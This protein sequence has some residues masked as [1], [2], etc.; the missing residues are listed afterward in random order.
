MMAVFWD[1][2]VK[3]PLAVRLPKVTVGPVAVFPPVVIASVEPALMATLVAREGDIDAEVAVRQT[4]TVPVL[5]T[6]IVPKPLSAELAVE[7]AAILSVPLSK[8][9]AL[10]PKNPPTPVEIETFTLLPVG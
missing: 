7:F 8:F 6:V 3:F 1:C 4:F 10:P 2:R 5:L 9:T